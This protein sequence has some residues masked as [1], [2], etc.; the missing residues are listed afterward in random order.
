MPKVRFTG[1]AYVRDRKYV[2]GQED[3]LDEEAAKDA[4]KSGVAA[5]VGPEVRAAVDGAPA[6]A[7]KAVKL[8][9]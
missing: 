8:G 1:T 3:D 6:A 4:V 2:R 5:I 9:G 7:R